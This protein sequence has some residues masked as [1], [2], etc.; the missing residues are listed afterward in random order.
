M[1]YE[2]WYDTTLAYFYCE[3][4]LDNHYKDDAKEGIEIHLQESWSD[5]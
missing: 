1:A 3:N 5:L 2:F 4:Y